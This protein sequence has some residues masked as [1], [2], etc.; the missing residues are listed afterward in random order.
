VPTYVEG[1]K[2]FDIAYQILN[3]DGTPADV[4]GS[5]VKFKMRTGAATLKVDAAATIVDGPSGKV[6]YTFVAADL[7][8]AASYVGEWEV[9]FAGG[10]KIMTA[11]IRERIDVVADLP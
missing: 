8:A 3:P 11:P 10:T 7:D 9:S 1:D 2:G 4:S 5:T 6:K